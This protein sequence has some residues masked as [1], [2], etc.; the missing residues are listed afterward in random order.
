[1]NTEKDSQHTDSWPLPWAQKPGYSK[2]RWAPANNVSWC[3]QRYLLQSSIFFPLISLLGGLSGVSPNLGQDPKCKI[4]TSPRPSVSGTYFKMSL[5]ETPR[6]KDQWKSKR[7]IF[8]SLGIDLQLVSQGEWLKG[9]PEW[10]LQA[11]FIL[12]RAQVSS[13]RLQFKLIG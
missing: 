11:V 2:N 6:D 13:A 12:F 10:L 3:F 8:W 7:F 4:L 5:S 1:M 9:D